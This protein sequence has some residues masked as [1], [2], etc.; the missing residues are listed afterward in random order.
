MDVN[1]IDQQLL[2]MAS[3]VPA[4]FALRKCFIFPW[5]GLFSQPLR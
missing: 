2:D 3:G 4:E 1:G 5:I